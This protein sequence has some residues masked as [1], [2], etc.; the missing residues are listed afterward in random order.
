VQPDLSYTIDVPVETI[1]GNDTVTS[2]VSGTDENNNPYSATTNREY[3]IDIPQQIVSITDE[4]EFEGDALVFEVELNPLSFYANEGVH[5]FNLTDITTSPA[6]YGSLSFSDGVIDNGNGTI[7]V[8]AGLTSFTVTVAGVEDNISESDETF[9][10]TIDG[11]EGA[12]GTGTIIDDDGDVRINITSSGTVEEGALALF[13][14]NLS[15]PSAS[16]VVVNLSATDGTADSSDYDNLTFYD[17]NGIDIGTTI[18]FSPGQTSINVYVQTINND[19]PLAEPLENFTVNADMIGGNSDSAQGGITDT[20][21]PVVSIDG[22]AADGTTVEEGSLAKFTVNLNQA[23][24]SSTTVNLSLINGTADASDYDNLKFYDENGVEISSTLVFAPGETSKDV[25]VQTI[26]NDPPLAEPLENY[27]VSAEMV[28]GNTAFAQGGIT[29][30]DVPVVSIDGVGAEGTIVEE[31]NLAKFT[32]SLN[33][34]SA[35]STTVN[36][37]LSDGTAD[38]TDYDNLKFYDENGVEISSTLVFAAG[39]T[40][41]DIYVQTIDNDPPLAEPLEN[42]TVNVAMVGGNTASAQGGITDSDIP[43]V[44]IDGITTDGTTVEEGSL[45]KFTVSLNEESASN[46]T[47]NLSLSD[48]TADASDYDSL[49]FYDENGVEISSTLVFTAGETS[50]DIYVQTIDNDPPL[51]EPLENYTVNVSMVGG[52]TASAQG[53]IT[54]S[55]IPVVS[56][57]GFAAEGTTVEEG[58][59]AKFTV[60]LNQPSGTA[61]TVNLSLTDGT[62]D[63][64]DYDNLKFYDENGIEISST[65]V[66]AAGETSRDIYVQ[67]IDNDP[68]VGEPLE[69]YTVNVAM[70]GG[71]T[72]SAQGGITDS[73]IPVVSIAGI[74]AD[75]TIVEEGSLAKFTVSLDQASASSTTVNLSLS[76]G[77]ANATDY[78]N[79]KFYDE[80]GVE[81]SSTLVFAAGETSK[82]IYVQTIDNDPPLAEP[83]ENYTVNV[84]MVGG[85]TASAVGGITDS[86]IP[87]VSIDGV[88]ADGTTV[89]EGNLAQFT[90][91]LNQ[92]SAVNTTINLSLTDGTAD[93]SDYDNL[94]FYDENGIEISSTLVF[95]AGETSKDIYVQTIDNDPPVGEPLENYTVNVA[96]VGGNTASAQGGITDGTVP[97]VSIDGITADGTTVEEGNLAKFTVNLDQASGSSTSVDLSLSDGTADASDYDNLKFYDENGV[98]I[99]STLVFAA[100]ETSKDIYVQTI[101]NDPPLAEPLENYTVTAAI[102]GGNSANAQGGITDSDLPVISVDSV[103]AIEG[104]PLTFTVSLNLA[105]AAPVTVSWATALDA[106]GLN[107]AQASDFT[108]ASGTLTFAPGETSKT[109]TIDTLLDN[110]NELNE[111]LLFNLSSASG[112]TIAVATGVGTIIDDD[113]PTTG[114]ATATVDE[115]GLVAGNGSNEAAPGDRVDSNLDNDNDETTFTGTLR[116]SVGHAGPGTFDFSSMDGQSA[117]LGGEDVSYGWN[118]GLNTLTATIDGGDRDG[119][120]LFDVVLNPTSGQYTVTLLTNAMHTVA[121]SEDDITAA[122]S[123]SLTDA[124]NLTTTGTLNVVI[125]DDLP[126][127]NGGEQAVDALNFNLMFALDLSASMNI[128][129]GISDGEGGTLTRF[130]AAIESINQLFDAYEQVGDVRVRLVTF[131]SSAAEVG[132]TWTNITDARALLQTLTPSGLTNY[133]AALEAIT[134]NDSF[135]TATGFGN[136]AWDDPGSF[137][138][139]LNVSYFAS[140]GNPNVEG[141]ITPA[142][143]GLWEDFLT[144]NEILSYA[145]GMGSSVNINQMNPIAYNG[146][147]EQNTDALQITDFAQLAE[148]ITA[149]VPPLTGELIGSAGA[150]GLSLFAVTIDG[151]TFSYDYDSDA[152]NVTGALAHTFD[153]TENLLTVTSSKNGVWMVDLDSGAF[154]YQADFGETGTDSLDFTLTDRDGDGT[155]TTLD[156]DLSTAQQSGQSAPLAASAA[157]NAPEESPLLATIGDDV[158]AWDLADIGAPGSPESDTIIDFG[159]AGSD[160]L[161]LSDLLTDAAVGP[162]SEI[163]NLDQ[164]LNIASDGADTVVR[165]SSSGGFSGGQFDPGAVDQEITLAG[166]DLGDD[167][168]QAI[169]DLLSSGQL[170]TD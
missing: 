78:D 161:D 164:F 103:Q 138:D 44:S 131:S 117:T 42:Y 104:Q 91:T 146:R 127:V 14:V 157:I 142:L 43:V 28:G 21:M 126:T 87:V 143:A 32:V 56:I 68:P 168:A 16:S 67:T 166:I 89:E 145:M 137:S 24:G 34:A 40:S 63:S 90:V 156:I 100:G 124:M 45:A 123:Y 125:D 92:A 66:F 59:L 70:V 128:S 53:G 41:K 13:V 105:S 106:L 167:S 74:T 160:A 152:L 55:D 25:Y 10:L 33:E 109:V 130:E 94:K 150:D 141:P 71:N 122:L 6:D 46:T 35:S 19:P 5:T 107:P 132:D 153:E 113:A 140:D 108:A 110:I 96:M 81:I 155:T 102:A 159:A 147:T 75:G 111:T 15:N 58:N 79:L 133:R 29:D 54:D 76:D 31:G 163:G 65:L 52:N 139:G 48:G 72:A 85:N 88:T 23:S 27:T 97:V 36:L 1:L 64:T 98:E 83:L 114:T 112:A 101:D 82:D 51:G 20:D 60:S 80:N 93:A 84:A 2:T 12:T 144:D 170:I 120:N 17:Q 154:T 135:S 69:N 118:V 149:T 115:D 136:G 7:T 50:K 151:T 73:D 61:T 95:A 30:S 62:A 26:D 99:S 121:G 57:D 134:G 38:A 39:E 165:I 119:T 129:T 86:D 116:G 4:T 9:T 11:V 8:P 77:T 3:D 18:E 37:S 162:A 148:T 22:V 49:N 169:R 158:F 47:V